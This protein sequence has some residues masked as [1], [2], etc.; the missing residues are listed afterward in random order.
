M[1][2]KAGKITRVYVQNML[3]DESPLDHDYNI[4]GTQEKRVLKRSENESWSL[5]SRGGFV[6]HC[7]DDGNS[8]K[9]KFED[10]TKIKLDYGQ[11]S[12]LLVLLLDNC[13]YRIDL[14]EGR[15]V[16]LIK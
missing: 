1:E 4:S 2:K 9:I 11:A 7:K 14:E 12:Q 5:S 8:I 16:K 6:A 10:G 15:T 13:D 3:D